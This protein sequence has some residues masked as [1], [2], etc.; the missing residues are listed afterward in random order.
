MNK[1]IKKLGT[2]LEMV[3]YTIAFAIIGLLVGNLGFSVVAFFG[4]SA[5]AA[6]V[7]GVFVGLLVF[8]NLFND[9][10][11]RFTLRRRVEKM[12]ENAAFDQAAAA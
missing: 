3:L 1:F 6:Q 7:V 11:A 5:T 8:A 2:M 10:M 9:M 4:L 12:F